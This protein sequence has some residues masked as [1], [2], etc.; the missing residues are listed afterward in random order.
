MG[1]GGV[2]DDRMQIGGSGSMGDPPGI[3]WSS[4]W[5]PH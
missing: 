4:V 2:G 1:Q 3:G 5:G